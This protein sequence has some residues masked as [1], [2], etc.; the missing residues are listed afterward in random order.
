ML[1]TSQT[2]TDANGQFTMRGVAPG[3]YVVKVRK[4]DGTEASKPVDVVE[5]A[6]AAVEIRFPAQ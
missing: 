6:S 3:S 4:D 2:K 5:G 1:T